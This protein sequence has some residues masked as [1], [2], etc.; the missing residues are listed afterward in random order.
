MSLQVTNI[1]AGHHVPGETSNGGAQETT[2]FAYS[3]YTN[4]VDGNNN[5]TSSSSSSSSSSGSSCVGGGGGG[6]IATGRGMTATGAAGYLPTGV[7]GMLLSPHF[8]AS[9]LV[10]GNLINS[11]LPVLPSCSSGA[12]C[13]HGCR[14]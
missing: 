3:S 2:S 14:H 13:M 11:G 9:L 12:R 8:A 6:G 10:R 7:T 1:A 4:N 5:V